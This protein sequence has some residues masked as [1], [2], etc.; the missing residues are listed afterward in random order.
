MRVLIAEDDLVSNKML[1]CLLTG[2]GYE[3]CTCADGQ[4]AWDII[5]SD[6]PPDIALL[7]W[8]MPGLTGLEVSQRSQNLE[9]G[10]VQFLQ[11]IFIS[12]TVEKEQIV[13]ALHS[14]AHDFLLKPIDAKLLRLRLSLAERTIKEK[15][16]WLEMDKVLQKYTT[17]VEKLAQERA[18]QLVHAERMSCLGTM[19]A[20][21]AHEINNPLSFVS[22]NVQ[23]LQTFWGEIEP[24][25]RPHADT[26]TKIK[27]ILEEFP[28]STESIRQGVT[29][30]AKIVKS[31]KRYAVKES[32]EKQKVNLLDCV[33]QAIELSKPAIGKGVKIA[34]N[35]SEAP[36]L[37]QGN[38]L[39]IEQVL[40]NLLVN[41]AQAMK[42]KS[43]AAI[44]IGADT[45]NGT[46]II[47][48]DDYGPGIPDELL[49][50]IWE[51]FFTTK[52]IGQGTG[53]GLAI[54]MGIVRDHQGDLKVVNRSSGGA[55]FTLSFPII[56]DTKDSDAAKA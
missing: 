14:G 17:Q 30:I 1:E 47:T 29:R 18:K 7:D 36:L 4:S 22:G 43:G 20:G 3:V 33:N 44:E 32:S 40:I 46:A 6:E 25:L 23:G 38:P 16:A 27:F 13:Q 41:A 49:K 10:K 51:P 37:V 39:E 56:N 8:F 31:L 50:K 26:N 48:I 9:D 5:A 2:W 19:C 11:R 53:L 55:R 15:R 28:K 21:V 24:I 54:S 12:A 42:D 34:T 52:P 35:F 45:Q